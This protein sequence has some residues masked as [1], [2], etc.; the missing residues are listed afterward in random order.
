MSGAARQFLGL[1]ECM[2]ELSPAGPDL[3][4]RGFAGDVFN[5]LWYARRA[6]GPEWQVA[7]HS[8]LGTDPLS[9][10]LANFAEA[11]GIDCAEV[12]RVADRV[13][14]LYLIHL[15]NGERSFSYWRDSSAARRMMADPALVARRIEGAGMVYLS[16]ITLAILPAVDAAALIG[17]MAEAKARGQAVAFDPNIRP[18]LWDDAARMREV[19]EAAAGAASLVLPSFDDEAAT[20]G[21]A[22]PAAT[23][24]RY[25]ALGC[26]HVV[27]K[28]GP[29]PVLTL[30]EGE[31]T[32]HPAPEVIA[33]PVDTT[34]AGDSFNA[35]YLAEI[36]TSGDP[37][38]AVAAGQA[39]A[40]RTVMGQGALVD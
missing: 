17:L 12:P 24:A 2:V 27:V 19:T 22:D 36:L 37:A 32:E 38:R 20:F 10:E 39:R 33:A 25:A 13:P 8:A 16:G 30:I 29:A 34:A 15:E 31:A 3:L 7:F 5:T 6:L 40:A 35:A 4:R 11:A 9:D 18:R 21:D 1:G 28:N 26:P 14:G 23:A